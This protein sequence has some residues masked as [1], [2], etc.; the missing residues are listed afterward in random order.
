MGQD[1]SKKIGIIVGNEQ[2][3][4]AAFLAAVNQVDGVTGELVKIGPTF[5]DEPIEYDVILDRVSHHIPY[6]RAYLKYAA[7][8]G[9]YLINDPLTK[10]IDQKFFNIAVVRQLGFKIPR[11]VV[12]PNK[13]LD[14]DMSP[15]LFRNL[16]YPMKWD[17]I[18][19]YVGVPAIMKDI[20]N[21]GRRD[22]RRISTTDELLRI[23]D[24]S[25]HR[26]MVLQE[27]IESDTHLHCFVVGQEHVLCLQ[28]S[29]AEQKYLDEVVENS[30]KVGKMASKAAIQISQAFKYDINMVEFVIDNDELYVINGTNPAPQIDQSLMNSEQFS[31]CV[32][33][34][35]DIAIERAKRPLPLKTVSFLKSS[36][37]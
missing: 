4:P 29:L 34:T 12:L 5:A 15:G 19:A 11:T 3:W 27:I 23:Y 1:S 32:A 16:K 28:Y 26:T 37:K 36:T 18:I 7:V 30:S 2:E 33:Q 8:N 9:A 17:E 20:K 14:I 13:Q 6:Y 31:W 22:V 25:G 21:G 35:V 24:E 10:A